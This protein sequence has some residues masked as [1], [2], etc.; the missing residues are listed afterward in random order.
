MS[1]ASTP[2]NDAISQEAFDRAL[3]SITGGA[4]AAANEDGPRRDIGP[5]PIREHAYEDGP[6]RDIGPRV[7]VAEEDGP[8]RDI[9]P[10]TSL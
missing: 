8:R 4:E 5:R 7:D 10:R 6:R 1:S 2:N 3:A 9:G